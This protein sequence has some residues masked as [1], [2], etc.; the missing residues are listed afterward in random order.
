MRRMM[1]RTPNA[2]SRRRRRARGGR[3]SDMIGMVASED[4]RGGARPWP[5]GERK[6]RVR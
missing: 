1:P 5:D 2:V 6:R 4:G 3:D